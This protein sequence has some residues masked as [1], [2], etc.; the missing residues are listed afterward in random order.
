MSYTD[1]KEFTLFGIH[2]ETD[3]DTQMDIIKAV[4]K[5]EEWLYW[6][7]YES[8]IRHVYISSESR[9][10]NQDQQK[11]SENR[12]FALAKAERDLTLVVINIIKA[13]IKD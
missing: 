13:H 1:K 3:Y 6:H 2:F 11:L 9:Q 4:R 12:A 5:T 8:M 7:A 10:I